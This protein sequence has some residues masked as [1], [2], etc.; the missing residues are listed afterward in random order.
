M[1]WSDPLNYALNHSKFI[2]IDDMSYVSTG[3][4]SFASFNANRDIFL[5]LREVSVVESLAELFDYD[6]NHTP[7]T[8]LHPNIITSPENSRQGIEG[9]FERAEDS[10]YMYFAYMSDRSLLEKVIK[11]AER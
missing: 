5:E 10:I 7:F 3:N 6:Y 9:L 11:T 4:Y 2:I 8:V 1:K